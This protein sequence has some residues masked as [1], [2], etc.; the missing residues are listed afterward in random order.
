MFSFRV[1]GFLSRVQ[2]R[3]KRKRKEGLVQI[4]QQC[5]TDEWLSPCL[6]WIAG[7]WNCIVSPSIFQHA[8]AA[9]PMWYRLSSKAM[10]QR[11]LRKY[12]QETESYS[13]S[14]MNLFVWPIYSWPISVLLLFFGNV[15]PTHNPKRQHR[16]SIPLSTFSFS[17]MNTRREFALWSFLP[18]SGKHGWA[19]SSWV[20]KV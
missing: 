14:V 9:F 17:A 20:L 18:T 4:T 13:K 3:S 2:Y 6:V 11:Q 15:S 5:S 1:K 19:S 7:Y 16:P 8:Q 12:L 10:R